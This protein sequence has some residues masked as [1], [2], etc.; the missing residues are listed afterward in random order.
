MFASCAAELLSA[1]K[2]S[3]WNEP[4]P[5]TEFFTR[6]NIPKNQQKLENRLKCNVYYYRANYLV[7]VLGVLALVFLRHPLGL[8]S[9]TVGALGGACM[10]DSFAAAFNERGLRLMRLINPQLASKLRSAGHAGL[11]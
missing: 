10:H 2:Q 8:L 7:L 3:E 6:F 11:G 9:I 5:L 4:R 1:L